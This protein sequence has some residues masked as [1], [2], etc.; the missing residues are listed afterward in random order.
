MKYSMTIVIYTVIMEHF[1]KKMKVIKMYYKY[2][3]S[4]MVVV[5]YWQSLCLISDLCVYDQ[6]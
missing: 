3:T 5:S 6:F 2:D 4:A 1:I